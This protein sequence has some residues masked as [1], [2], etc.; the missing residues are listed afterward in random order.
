M[1][2][3]DNR[4]S[5]LGVSN[6]ALSL[7]TG[8]WDSMVCSAR[9]YTSILHS[10]T[11]RS[12]VFGHKR[13]AFKHVTS[14][15]DTQLGHGRMHVSL[16]WPSHELPF[17]TCLFNI[18]TTHSPPG[19][20]W[21]LRYCTGQH[22][23][24]LLEATKRRLLRHFGGQAPGTILCC[25]TFPFHTTVSHLLSCQQTGLYSSPGPEIRAG[26]SHST[27]LSIPPYQSSFTRSPPFPT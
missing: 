21:T 5:C 1:Q 19:E 23:I 16:I 8:S 11:F 9:R 15:Y 6:D 12:Y 7:C 24:P 26:C 10:L 13:T 18:P 14:C 17:Q 2:G 22:N 3:H 25:D 20:V 4:V 27:T